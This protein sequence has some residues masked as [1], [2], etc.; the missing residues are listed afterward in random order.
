LFVSTM[1]DLPGKQSDWIDEIRVPLMEWWTTRSA[2][3]SKVIGICN[4]ARSYAQ[5]A[6]A[7]ERLVVHGEKAGFIFPDILGLRNVAREWMADGVPGG[8]VRET[9]VFGV[10]VPPMVT[11]GKTLDMTRSIQ[12]L[13]PAIEIG[14]AEPS[15]ADVQRGQLDKVR[16][17]LYRHRVMF[18]GEFGQ[19][20]NTVLAT[21]EK[22]LYN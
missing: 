13:I 11:P 17:A 3:S 4:P 7:V 20:V 15:P 1:T 8:L 14:P 16:R 19:R 6:Q 9:T 10:S 5:S 21:L 12:S 18:E 22:I 2:V